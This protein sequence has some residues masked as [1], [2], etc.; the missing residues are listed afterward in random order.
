T[1]V[2]INRREMAEKLRVPLHKSA[3][4]QLRQ[5]G[6]IPQAGNQTRRLGPISRGVTAGRPRQPQ[7]PLSPSRQRLPAGHHARWWRAEGEAQ[8]IARAG[9][10]EAIRPP[11]SPASGLWVRGAGA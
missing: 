7:V 2:L 3:S 1:K 6:P 10:F 5:R 11:V 9:E 4:R 8:G